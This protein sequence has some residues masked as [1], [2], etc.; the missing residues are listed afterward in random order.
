MASTM[1]DTLAKFRSM[2]ELVAQLKAE[3]A[4]QDQLAAG[5]DAASLLLLALR[6]AYKEAVLETE[7]IK[8]ATSVL[9]T[10]L[11]NTSLQL[12][13]LLYEK[14]HFQR[15]T[16]ANL[17]YQSAVADADLHLVPPQQFLAGLAPEEAAALAGDE[18]ALM[19]ARLKHELDT[20]RQQTEE[21][22]TVRGLWGRAAVLWGQQP[23]VRCGA[24]GHCSPAPLAQQAAGRVPTPCQAPGWRASQVQALK[25][26]EEEKLANRKE[27]VDGMHRQLEKVVEAAKPI[28]DALGGLPPHIVAAGGQRPPTPTSRAAGD[29]A[30]PLLL[31]TGRRVVA[32]R[33]ASPP[34]CQARGASRLA[35]ARPRPAAPSSRGSLQAPPRACPRCC[36]CPSTSSGRSAWR[37]S[38]CRACPCRSVSV[39]RQGR[40]RGGVGAGQLAGWLPAAWFGLLASAL[41]PHA[42]AQPSPPDQQHVV[43]SRACPHSACP[44]GGLACTCRWASA[45]TQTPQPQW[46]PPRQPPPLTAAR[47]PRPSCTRCAAALGC[48]Q[49][50]SLPSPVPPRARPWRT[51]AQGNPPPPRA[52]PCRSAG[53]PARRG[54]QHPAARQQQQRRRQCQRQRQRLHGRRRR[55]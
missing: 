18:H 51:A 24:G 12:H 34:P 17:S 20:R 37:R 23:R 13:N 50:G 4:S 25:A 9:K 52:V 14:H 6:Q 28:A 2:V 38:R 41:G 32:A 30:P 55:R 33:L 35:D 19:L 10:Q 11:D 7:A 46:T 42:R 49:P 8:D 29:G 48:L 36:R 39:R 44:R 5:L 47:R 1:D 45:A 54:A 31:A 53:P 15:E 21:L 3:G 22:K 27:V 26:A 43:P 16:H 40:R